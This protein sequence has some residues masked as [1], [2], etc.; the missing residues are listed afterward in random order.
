[1]IHKLTVSNQMS[2]KVKE[3]QAEKE[4]EKEQEVVTPVYLPL[5]YHRIIKAYGGRIGV[6]RKTDYTVSQSYSEA[7][8]EFASQ[9]PEFNKQLIA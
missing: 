6:E 1:M 9:L 5:S 8:K 7:L 2:E 4:H 3:T